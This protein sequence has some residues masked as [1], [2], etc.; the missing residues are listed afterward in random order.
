M[1][2]I[3]YNLS[4]K[5]IDIFEKENNELFA[6]IVI[7]YIY[8]IDFKVAYNRDRPDLQINTKDISMGIEVTIALDQKSISNLKLLQKGNFIY[9]EYFDLAND[10]LVI[11]AINKKIRKDKV[12]ELIKLV[13][14]NYAVYYA[15]L[16]TLSR[17]ANTNDIPFNLQKQYLEVAVRL[18]HH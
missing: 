2:F 14:L 12:K 6:L 10:N 9:D 17:T 7:C 18:G 16:L 13:K 4:M 11:N 5:Y 3:W 1:V 8:D 15:N